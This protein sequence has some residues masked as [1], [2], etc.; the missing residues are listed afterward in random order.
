MLALLYYTCEN[1]ISFSAIFQYEINR[2][3]FSHLW[4]NAGVL[5]VILPVRNLTRVYMLMCLALRKKGAHNHTQIILPDKDV[6]S[7]D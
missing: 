6:K 2:L 3:Y 5:C 1:E 7:L 4:F